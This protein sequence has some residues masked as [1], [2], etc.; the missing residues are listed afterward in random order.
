MWDA[1]HQE[2]P[3]LPVLAARFETDSI[4]IEHQQLQVE[5]IDPIEG[6]VEMT[7]VMLDLEATVVTTN[8]EDFEQLV[9]DLPADLSID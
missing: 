8:L 7:I 6:V 5:T 2:A 9:L 3:V 4:A 1:L